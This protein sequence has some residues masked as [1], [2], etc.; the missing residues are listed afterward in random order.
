MRKGKLPQTRR[1]ILVYD[2]DWAFLHQWFGKNSPIS[3]VSEAVRAIIHDKVR[4]FKARQEQAV[5][6]GD[7]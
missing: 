1:H 7:S 4:E 6:L 3:S 5:D 2:E